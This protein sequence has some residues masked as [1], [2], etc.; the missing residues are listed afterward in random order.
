MEQLHWFDL[1]ILIIIG[2]T[3]VRG[4]FSGFIMQAATLLGVILGA[5][6]AGKLS[7]IIAPKLMELV[8]ASSHIISPLSYI[9][10]FVLIMIA[11]I[12]A[13]KLLESAIDALKMTAL[14]R[15]AGA[16]FCAVKWLI[17]FSIILNIVV[18][19]DQNRQ[20]IKDDVRE[21][22]VSYPYIMKIAQTVI[23]YLRFDD[24]PG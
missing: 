3:L 17:V 21:T 13:G 9:V 23:P 22:S 8:N 18:E 2:L 6:F 20:L 15:L 5:I 10:A 16:I 7:E 1:V 14:N 4:A 24:Y 12:F 19:F 11:L